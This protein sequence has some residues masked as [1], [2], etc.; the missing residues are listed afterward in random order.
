M[1]MTLLPPKPFLLLE[2]LLQRKK[3][4]SEPLTRDN[5]KK[6]DQFMS[7]SAKGS[8]IFR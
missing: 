5:S 4:L 1:P 3:M 7:F 6:N 8:I 2:Q